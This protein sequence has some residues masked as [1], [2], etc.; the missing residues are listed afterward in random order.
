MKN[1]FNKATTRKLDKNF[2]KSFW[3]KFDKEFS[4]EDLSNQNWQ[5]LF[6]PIVMAAVLLVLTINLYQGGNELSNQELVE[7]SKN[8][9]E[10][11]SIFRSVEI[12][13]DSEYYALTD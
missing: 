13:L 6:A 1:K 3:T 7:F 4:K 8:I 12:D 9:E 11:D 2:D 10:V 5:K